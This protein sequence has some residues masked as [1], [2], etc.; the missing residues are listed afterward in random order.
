MTAF[1]K[2]LASESGRKRFSKRRVNHYRI[3][4]IRE[5]NGKPVT[6]DLM[7]HPVGQ[8]LG[9]KSNIVFSGKP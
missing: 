2:E 6:D 1:F 9:Q 7:G 5:S 8:A 3:I 4:R